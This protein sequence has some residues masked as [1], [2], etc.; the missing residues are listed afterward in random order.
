MCSYVRPK[1][2]VISESAL[3]A[4]LPDEIAQKIAHATFLAWANTDRFDTMVL[5]GRAMAHLNRAFFH[6]FRPMRVM[7]RH[8]PRH[9]HRAFSLVEGVLRFLHARPL[10]PSK[11]M[12]SLMHCEVYKSCRGCKCGLRNPHEDQNRYKQA[13]KTINIACT[14]KNLLHALTYWL[15]HLYTSGDLPKPTNDERDLIIRVLG[16]TF[17]YVDRYHID[18]MGLPSTHQHLEQAYAIVDALC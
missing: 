11:C 6:A 18:H 12:Y 5:E 2:C 3:W 7:L 14:Q 1:K 17:H 4:S 9:P 10:L 13:W 16:S 8:G 15:I